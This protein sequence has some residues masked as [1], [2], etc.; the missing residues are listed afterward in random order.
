MASGLT[1]GAYNF[2]L[3]PDLEI[4]ELKLA[5]FDLLLPNLLPKSDDGVFRP[6]RIVRNVI[7]SGVVVR[8]LGMGLNRSLQLVEGLVETIPRSSTMRACSIRQLFE[9]RTNWALGRPKGVLCAGEKRLQATLLHLYLMEYQ[10]VDGI[11]KMSTGSILG[12]LGEIV[13]GGGAVDCLSNRS[14][15]H[16][17]PAVMILAE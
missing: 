9:R 3:L 10:G 15:C 14:C 4:L 6:A 12:D 17:A 1:I 5:H 7:N 8:W 16:L 11:A 2:T 13:Q